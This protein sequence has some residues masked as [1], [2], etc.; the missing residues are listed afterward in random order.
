M[1]HWLWILFLL[2]SLT[3]IGCGS[4]PSPAQPAS[5]S[6]AERQRFEQDQRR[7]HDEEKAHRRTTGER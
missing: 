2:G 4:Q 5:P 7:I 1:L 3:A 6:D